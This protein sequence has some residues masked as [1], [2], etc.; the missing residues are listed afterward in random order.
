MCIS[1]L[2]RSQV[3]LQDAYKILDIHRDVIALLCRQAVLLRQLP[4]DL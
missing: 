3:G 2:R 4:K 1:L